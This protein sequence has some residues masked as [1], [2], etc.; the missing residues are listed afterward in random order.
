VRS[1]H[2]IWPR[3]INLKH[4]KCKRTRLSLAAGEGKLSR[5]RELCEWRAGIDEADKYGRTSLYFASLTGHLAVVRELLARG[6]NVNV[7]NNVSG[8]T[9]LI[10]ASLF[11]HVDVLR[12]LLAAGANKHHVD[13]SGNTATSCAGAFAGVKPAA[14]AAVLTRLAAAP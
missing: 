5:V 7:A 9:P 3:I 11:G 4:G 12:A 1:G 6:A 13:N 8:A 14:K 10:M 2:P